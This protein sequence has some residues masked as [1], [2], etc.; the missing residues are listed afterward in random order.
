MKNSA[1]KAI[2]EWN[3]KYGEDYKKLALGFNFLKTCKK[4]RAFLTSCMMIIGK[5]LDI[6]GRGVFYHANLHQIKVLVNKN[7]FAVV[8]MLEVLFS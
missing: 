5:D 3:D 7:Y 8:K 6:G 2:Q 4:V 1:L